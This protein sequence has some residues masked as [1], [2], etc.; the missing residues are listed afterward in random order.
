MFPPVE[1]SIT[2]SAPPQRASTSL[3]SSSRQSFDEADVPMLAFTLVENA[4]PIAMGSTSG[5]RK[6]AGMTASRAATRTRTS[7]PVQSGASRA[8]RMN[9]AKRSSPA[10]STAAFTAP[11]MRFSRA[12]T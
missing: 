7:S 5:C 3:P 4:S 11:R 12:A 9:P 2:V 6:E 8:G 10:A 1:R